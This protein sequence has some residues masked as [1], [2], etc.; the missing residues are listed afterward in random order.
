MKELRIILTSMCSTTSTANDHIPM[1]AIKQARCQLEPQLLH[2][3]NKIILTSKYPDRLNI[4]KIIP[5]PK[6]PKDTMRIDG[7]HPINIVPAISKVVKKVILTQILKHLKDSNLIHQNHHGSVKNHLTHTLILE[8]HNK[9]VESMETGQDVA[10]LQLDQSKA[11][12]LISHP[13]LIQ[14]MR[15]LKFNKKTISTIQSY[16]DE[17]RQY[18]QIENTE[19]DVLLV[20]PKSVTQGLTLSC[21]FYLIFIL[22]IPSICHEQHHNPKEA[23][24]CN[25]PNIDTFVDDNFVRINKPD[26]DTFENAVKATMEKIKDYMDANHLTLNGDKDEDHDCDKEQSN[27]R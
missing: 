7:W 11:Y 1:K 12:N 2:L 14:K 20:G 13:I 9:L 5:I 15:L 18:V 21:L 27:Q 4:T 6:P 22:D 16:L 26:N 19:S 3:T 23:K 25:K 10:L 17:R 24:D 8:L